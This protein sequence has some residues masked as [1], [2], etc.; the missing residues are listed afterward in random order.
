MTDLAASGY[1]SNAARTVPEMK[2]AI[3]AL[4]DV[5]AE[6]PGGAAKA[7][8]N[9]SAG[10]IT[11]AAQVGGGLIVV[12]TGGPAS[13]TL[14]TINQTNARDGLHL[15]LMCANASRVV[16][17]HHAGGGTGQILTRDSSDFVLDAT[18]K[19]ILLRR[20]G[21]DWIEIDRSY[22]VDYD[23]L[24]AFLQ[25]ATVPTHNTLCPHDGLAL[26]YASASTVT[27]SARAVVLA[28][29]AGR[30]KRFAPL[31]ETLNIANTNAN[32]RD[33][34]HNAGAE[35]ASTWY[36]V[37]AV[38][39]SDGTID[40]FASPDCY[41]GSATSIFSRLPAGYAYAG[42]IGAAYNDVSSN[43]RDFRQRGDEV[44]GF[45]LPPVLSDGVAATY[46]AISLVSRV[47]ITAREV[48][49]DVRALASGTVSYVVGIVSSE[50][51]G[52]TGSY[53]FAIA[54]AGGASSA[55]MVA[56]GSGRV[57]LTTPQQV[58]YFAL[59]SSVTV[60]VVSWRF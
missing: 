10:A 28:N 22:G 4:R 43:L 20:D 35:A 41:P 26:D 34:V 5:I 49:L 7:S 60:N 30:M 57:V 45:Q 17:V 3:E 27:I 2:T 56:R 31:S 16:T 58:M 32:G 23:K 8:Q 54:E 11:P 37:W 47:P 48:D 53:S 18:D 29:S 1:L 50:G 15:R 36:H 33:V 44:A 38:G 55:S 51:S 19:W 21:T 24:L 9:V 40:S 6:S 25:V 14:N 12:D 59:S 13:A 52:T 39:K 42:Y 46:T